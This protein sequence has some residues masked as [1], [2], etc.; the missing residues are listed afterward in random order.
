MIRMFRQ[1]TLTNSLHTALQKRAGAVGKRS[2][3]VELRE[4]YNQRMQ[5][6]DPATDH[7]GYA[8]AR[9]KYLDH[10]NDVATHHYEIAI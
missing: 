10:C 3:S 1:H 9:Q 5:D 2:T 7:W 4:Y 6:I 8:N